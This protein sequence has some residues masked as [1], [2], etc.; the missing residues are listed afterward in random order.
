MGNACGAKFNRQLAIGKACG[1]I[2]MGNACGAMGNRQFQIFKSSH[3][4]IL[5]S[6]IGTLVLYR[7][8]P[9]QTQ[10][11]KVEF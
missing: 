7:S 1:A 11:I 10:Q 6:L 2:S 5:K 3:P 8:K 9:A 4:Q